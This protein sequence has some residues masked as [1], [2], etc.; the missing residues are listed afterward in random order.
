MLPLRARVDFGVMAIKEYS[1]FP[2]AP[3]LVEPHNE[4]VQCHIQV[5]HGGGS[6]PSI[7]V[8]SVYST[9]PADWAIY[10]SKLIV[11]FAHNKNV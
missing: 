4:I 1:T 3:A 9:A 8:Q 11:L 10:L 2:K 7:E 6:Y 5:T